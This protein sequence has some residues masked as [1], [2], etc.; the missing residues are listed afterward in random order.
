VSNTARPARYSLTSLLAHALASSDVGA[1]LISLS[2]VENDLSLQ[3]AERKMGRAM[4][5]S[6]AVVGS[7]VSSAGNHTPFSSGGS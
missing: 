4:E 7:Q 1:K 3:A 2:T 6:S 5:H